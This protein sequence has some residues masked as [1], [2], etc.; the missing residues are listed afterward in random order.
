MSGLQEKLNGQSEWNKAILYD[1]NGKIIASTF[2]PLDGEVAYVLMFY[3][4]CIFI[5]AWLQL[6]QDRNTSI[7]KGIILLNEQYDIHRY[8]YYLKRVKNE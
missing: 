6:Y 3:M 8:L 5:S 7:G 2:T 4:K 1:Q